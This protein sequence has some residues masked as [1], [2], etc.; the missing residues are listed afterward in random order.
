MDRN[1]SI[2]LDAL[3]EQ[4]IDTM[5][6]EKLAYWKKWATSVDHTLEAAADAVAAGQRLLHPRNLI[7]FIKILEKEV[8]IQQ[9]EAYI[10]SIG[11]Q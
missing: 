5:S 4:N 2:L 1:Y 11:R 8:D 6:Y 10:A 3:K 9:F 7:H